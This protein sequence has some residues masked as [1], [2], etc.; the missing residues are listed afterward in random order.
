M[1][2]NVPLDWNSGN[3]TIEVIGDGVGTGGASSGAHGVIVITYAS[4]AE[5]NTT[6]FA[7]MDGTWK[8]RL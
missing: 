3:N 8:P 1:S 4:A 2:T 7:T 5:R 6:I